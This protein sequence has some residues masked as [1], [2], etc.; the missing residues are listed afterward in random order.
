MVVMA[1]VSSV[2]LTD[3]EVAAAVMDA[4][5]A[6]AMAVVMVA[7]EWKSSVTKNMPV[8]P[9]PLVSFPK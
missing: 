4:V 5:E 3:A 7:I 1:K 2:Q 6:V 8:A 9:T